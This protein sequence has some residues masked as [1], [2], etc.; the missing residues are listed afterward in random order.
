[1]TK[2]HKLQF[3]NKIAK[4]HTL[5]NEQLTILKESVGYQ[6]AILADELEIIKL[7]V[8]VELKLF[9]KRIIKI[10]KKS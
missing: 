1:M 5:T 9:F 2:N 7:A 3:I 4:G 6:R 8:F 10:F